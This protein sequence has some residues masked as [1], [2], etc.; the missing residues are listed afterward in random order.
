MSNLRTAARSIA[1]SGFF[2]LCLV[3]QGHAAAVGFTGVVPEEAMNG[4]DAV[5]LSEGN[6][7]KGQGRFTYVYHGLQWRFSSAANK[8][9]FQADPEAYTGE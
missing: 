7:V 6:K 9:E 2:A 3:S 5:E 8:H 4:Y 1:L